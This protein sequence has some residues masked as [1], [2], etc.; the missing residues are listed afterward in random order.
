MK[1]TRNRK[2]AALIG[3]LVVALVLRLMLFSRSPQ[4]ELNRAE[5]EHLLQTHGLADGR[6]VP[7]PFAG[8]YH[9]EGTRQSKSKTE[10]VFITTHLDE[11]QVKALFEQAGLKV[12]VPGE[13]WHGQAVNACASL[14]I[15]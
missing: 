3:L 5:F 13:G 9:V 15:V 1:F 14:V 12:D 6:A 10:K 2:W 7:T 8:I 4:R 11:A